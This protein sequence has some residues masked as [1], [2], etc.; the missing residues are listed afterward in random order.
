M[1]VERIRS[2]MEI[3]TVAEKLQRDR[4]HSLLPRHRYFPAVRPMLGYSFR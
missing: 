2:S 3:A 1:R 4:A